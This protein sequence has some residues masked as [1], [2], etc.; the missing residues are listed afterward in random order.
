MNCQIFFQGWQKCFKTHKICIETLDLGTRCITLSVEPQLNFCVHTKTEIWVPML[1]V[2]FIKPCAC[3]VLF[4]KSQSLWN[5][6]TPTVSPKWM[7]KRYSSTVCISL[8]L[9]AR[10]TTKNNFIDCMVS[11]WLLLLSKTIAHECGYLLGPYHKFITC[12]CKTSSAVTSQSSKII[13][14]YRLNKQWAWC[15]N[16]S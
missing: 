5:Y 2:R 13:N 15:K 3:L 14:D 1:F 12:S 9:A 6:F 7:Y 11:A 16:R 8:L 10:G 4:Y